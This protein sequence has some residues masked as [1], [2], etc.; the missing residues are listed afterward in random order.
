MKLSRVPTFISLRSAVL[1]FA[2]DRHGQDSQ[3]RK[4][5]ARLMCHDTVTADK[6]YVM[7]LNIQQARKGCFLYK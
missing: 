6:H 3:A 5:M 7:D 1:T 4:S 2:R